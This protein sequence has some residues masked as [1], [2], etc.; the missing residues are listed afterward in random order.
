MKEFFKVI[1]FLLPTFLWWTNASLAQ[2]AE[3]I[4]VDQSYLESVH[5]FSEDQNGLLYIAT[6]SGFYYLNGRH[7]QQIVDDQLFWATP[8]RI[9][10]TGRSEMWIIPEDGIPFMFDPHVQKFKRADHNRHAVSVHAFAY[11]TTRQI[12]WMASLQQGLLAIEKGVVHEIK[13]KNASLNESFASVSGVAIDA[14]GQLWMANP[15]GQ[16]AVLDQDIELVHLFNIHDAF[17][18]AHV[19]QP[20]IYALD[21]ADM[22]VQINRQNLIRISLVNY[23]QHPLTVTS[24]DSLELFSQPGINDLVLDKDKN[25]WVGTESRG[26]W[27]YD[28]S[29][30]SSTFI[31]FRDTVSYGRRL[32]SI[33]TLYL[34]KSGVVWIGT[35][36]HG[37]F[38]ADPNQK[39]FNDIKS[40]LTTDSSY[41]I[42]SIL[43]LAEEPNGNLWFGTAGQG[44]FIYD[45]QTSF[46]KRVSS[47]N[48]RPN[49]LSNDRVWSIDIDK[50]GR[51]WIGTQ[52]GLNVVSKDGRVLRT[53]KKGYKGLTDNAIKE[54]FVDSRNNVWVGSEND[55]LNVFINGQTTPLSIRYS[56]YNRRSISQ[57]EISCIFEDNRHRIWIGTKYDGLNKLVFPLIQ[58][59]PYINEKSSFSFKKYQHRATDTTT[60]NNNSIHCIF[61]DSKGQLYIG[62]D[63]GINLYDTLTEHF[64]HI[65]E[66]NNMPLNAVYSIE[67]DYNGN[68]WIASG[69]GLIKYERATDRY[70]IF[71]REDGLSGER[72]MAGTSLLNQNGQL[73]F[74]QENGAI[75]FL[76]EEIEPNKKMANPILL[77]LLVYDEPLPI[78]S[79]ELPEALAF[80]SKINLSHDQNHVTI[81]YTSSNYTQSEKNRYKYRLLGYQNEWVV[82]QSKMARFSNLEPGDYVFEIVTANNDG[83]WNSKPQKLEIVIHPAI[84]NR[85]WFRYMIILLVL[86]VAAGIVYL[87][88]RRITRQK[89]RLEREVRRRTQQ[90]E[91]QKREIERKN[92]ELANIN[93]SLE[94]KV[95]ER[96]VALQ[97]TLKKLIKTDEELN[98]FLYRTSHDLRGPVTTFMGLTQLARMENN[99]DNV[100]LYLEKIEGS[101][102]KLLHVLKKLNDVNIIFQQESPRE[103]IALE[104]FCRE[105]ESEYNSYAKEEKVK[106]EFEVTDTKS[107]FQN[108]DLVKVVV[109]NLIENGIQF[110]TYNNPFVKISFRRTIDEISVFVEDNGHGIS[111]DAHDKIYNM[112][113]RASERSKGSGL[114]LYITQKAVELMDGHIKFTSKYGHTT[115]VVT[116]PA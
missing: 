34:D 11:D 116:I 100:L 60:I 113:Y 17:T 47:D 14:M 73:I 89:I 16:I 88:F 106:M 115:F 19:Y 35:K 65:S 55:G 82:T 56:P 81:R 95:E 30:E 103:D 112:F 93:T 43:S 83:L 22:L 12:G 57:N 110:H 75:F 24:K 111:A 23:R 104:A 9:F 36:R 96:T 59:L 61:Q 79:D 76:P 49:K 87:R 63:A 10:E 39:N 26:L 2:T 92:K 84:W 64:H 3:R 27:K 46:A 97:K 70:F 107:I 62:T 25:L 7:L 32:P 48:A 33:S 109:T 66:V 45:P 72:F 50:Y 69:G 21:S 78:G 102:E 44:L 18:K 29:A 31:P 80:V 101:G 28:F 86:I 77:D 20:K 42:R 58:D 51:G 94:D 68:L 54:V 40:L 53:Y 74:G 90:I 37:I 38:K 105:L 108:K 15:S 85:S 5:A 99:N 52:Y 71:D 67:E 98:T 41:Q 91:R 8:E 4:F 114:G 1:I 13:F 6:D